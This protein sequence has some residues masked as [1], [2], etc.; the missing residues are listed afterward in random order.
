MPLH[1]SNHLAKPKEL[2]VL[3]I[4]VKSWKEK[5][6]T[7]W[8]MLCSKRWGTKVWRLPSTWMCYRIRWTALFIFLGRCW[9]VHKK[10][11]L[12]Y[13]GFTQPKPSHGRTFE[14]SSVDL[15]C[16]RIKHWGWRAENETISWCNF[17]WIPWSGGVLDW[18]FILL[19]RPP[20]LA[21]YATPFLQTNLVSLWIHICKIIAE[22]H[23]YWLII[24]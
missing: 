6:S 3:L 11:R 13:S 16:D 12:C 18:S 8:E 4:Y 10:F 5:S 19:Y 17:S 2:D 1:H 21:K 22:S 15:S 7:C 9:G 24:A 14:T 23:W 20:I